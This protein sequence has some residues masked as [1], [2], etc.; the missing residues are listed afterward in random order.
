[1]KVVI[2]ADIFGLCESSDNLIKYLSLHTIE[3]KVVEPYQGARHSF[4][5]EQE[6]YG[7]FVEKCGHDRYLSLVSKSI[8]VERPDLI[9]GFSA[10]ASAVWRASNYVGLDHMEAICF[11]P[12][13]I[14]NHLDINPKIS[15][16]VIFPCAEKS[17]D[18]ESI[19]NHISVYEGVSTE[20]TPFQHGFMNRCSSAYD[21]AGERYGFQLIEKYLMT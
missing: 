18:V 7:V 3:A 4:L 8:L 19:S 9:I 13:Q 14:R 2:V 11:Y 21:L 6:A 17:F 20:I 12:T 5:N 1:M 16:K 15:T 10:G